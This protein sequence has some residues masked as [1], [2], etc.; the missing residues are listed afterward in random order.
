M[1]DQEDTQQ[2]DL[3]E[4]LDLD[5]DEV[6][7]AKKRLPD[8]ALLRAAIIGVLVFVGAAIGKPELAHNEWVDAIVSGYVVAAPL[9]LAWWLRRHQKV[10]QTVVVESVASDDQGGKHRAP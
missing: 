2:L 9:G 5:K 3:T 6:E 4:L 7:Q 10:I 1:A 8:S